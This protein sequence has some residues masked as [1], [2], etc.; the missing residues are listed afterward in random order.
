MQEMQTMNQLCPLRTFRLVALNPEARVLQKSVS[1]PKIQRKRL[2][3]DDLSTITLE[4]D[5]RTLENQSESAWKF[6]FP[7]ESIFLDSHL[8]K[9]E[10]GSGRKDIGFETTNVKISGFDI[11]QGLE[12]EKQEVQIK[13]ERIEEMSRSSHSRSQ[14]LH[15][16]DQFQ[17]KKDFRID[18]FNPE[19]ESLE[20]THLELEQNQATLHSKKHFDQIFDQEAT[21]KLF[22][23]LEPLSKREHKDF[24]E[25]KG[26]I[27]Q[28]AKPDSPNLK[29]SKSGEVST[30]FLVEENYN[31]GVTY[32]RVQT[33][34]GEGSKPIKQ[35]KEAPLLNEKIFKK[36]SL[37]KKRPSYSS[38]RESAHYQIRKS[39]EKNM[40]QL[41]G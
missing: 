9:D 18:T 26:Q 37:T 30:Q 19:F 3:S 21:D 8:K 41:Q 33:K 31:F 16:P 22:K 38:K 27:N 10:F 14:N 17:P 29:P 5:K 2:Y 39:N 20:T 12:F 7:K 6:G 34:S 25:T 40:P 1:P 15:N 11:G 13:L 24:V 32:K 36:K 28:K 4:N 23:G 35:T